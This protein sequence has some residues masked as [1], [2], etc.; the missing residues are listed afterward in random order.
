MNVHFQ[1]YYIDGLEPF[2]RY[3]ITLQVKNPEY[4]SPPDTIS[5]VTSQGVPSRPDNV[6]FLE[7]TDRSMV[8]GWTPPRQPNGLL[9]GYTVYWTSQQAAVRS[10]TVSA[11]D[12]TSY[13][14]ATL[15]KIP[16]E[17]GGLYVRM[18]RNCQ[19]IQLFSTWRHQPST[20]LAG[21]Q[22]TGVLVG[23]L[24]LAVTVVIAVLWR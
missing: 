16:A 17:A 14:L 19:Q 2:T 12:V 23:S 3:E 8:L 9:L 5:A 13:T 15:G 7:V 11:G 10:V 21:A 4:L 24:L 22:L 1:K 18:E 6:T 20:A